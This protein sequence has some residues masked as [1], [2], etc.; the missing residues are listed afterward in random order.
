[1]LYGTWNVFANF[2]GLGLLN[3]KTHTVYL[4][5]PWTVAQRV[6]LY[7]MYV[8]YCVFIS[9]AKLPILER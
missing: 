7:G 5:S 4:G 2:F 1:M 9:T 3:S 8:L 6:I